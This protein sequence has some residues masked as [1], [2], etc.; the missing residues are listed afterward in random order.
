MEEIEGTILTGRSFEPV[1][2]RV[3]VEDGRITA[4]EETTG[5]DGE[6]CRRS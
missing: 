3:V 2:G 6:C 5:R 1:H 4:V